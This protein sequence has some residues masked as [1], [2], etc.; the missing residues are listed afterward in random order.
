[1]NSKV[2]LTITTTPDKA[3]IQLIDIAPKYKDG[4][5]LLPGEYQI[6]ISKLGY[7]SRQETLTLDSSNQRFSYQLKREIP[8]PIQ[9]LI[10]NMQ[11]IP[12]GSFMMG[13]DT[14]YADEKPVRRVNIEGF[15]LMQT[16]VTWAMY[17]PCIDAGTC[18]NNQSDGGGRGWGKGTRPV[19]NVSWN[20]ITQKYIP[21]LNKTTGQSFR[22]P[23]EAEWEYAARAGSVTHYGWGDDIGSNNANCDG[24]GSQWDKKRTAPVKSFTPNAFGLYD[25]YGN[26]LEWVQDCWNSSYQ[27]ASTDGHAWMRGDCQRAV[28]RGGSWYSK[29]ADLR[30]AIRDRGDRTVR[31]AVIGFRLMQDR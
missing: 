9:A 29:R 3:T 11:A 26:V 5:R 25:M 6:N 7:H 1:D 10:S 20:D 15:K 17:Q 28:V 8:N 16:E 31:N 2:A 18:S 22:L 30:S 4:I 21:W 14:G 23:S 13:S 27:D 19:I 24:C 12:A